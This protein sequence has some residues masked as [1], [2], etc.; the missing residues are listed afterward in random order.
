MLLTILI[1]L[2]ILMALVLSHEFGHFLLARLG[3]VRVEEFGFGFPPRLFSVQ[4]GETSYSFNLVPLGGFVKIKGEEGEDPNDPESFSAKPFWLKIAILL[5]GVAFNIV[6][7]YFLISGGYV[8]GTPISLEDADQNP[9]ALVVITAIQKDSPAARSGLEAGDTLIGIS[10]GGEAATISK[11]SEAQEFINAHR[12]QDVVVSIKRG[13]KELLMPASVRRETREGE[14]ALG[15]Q[16]S[17]IGIEKLGM[18]A[19]LKKG[20]SATYDTTIRTAYALG[21]FFKEIFAGRASFEEVSGPVGIVSIVGDF[22]RL[23]LIFLIQLTAFLSINLALINLIPFPGL[24]GGRALFLVIEKLRGRP[25]SFAA[26]RFIH[27]AGF[28]A[29]IL[30]MIVITYHDIARLSS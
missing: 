29:L 19:A 15:I 4:K 24:D 25:I 5:A 9:T 21:A 2:V 13:G 18:F 16:M 30:L 7:A 20:A 6:L 17:R 1:F 8:L 27:A 26:S 28:A 10:A 22:S 11:I 12:G 3:G 23:G 14:G